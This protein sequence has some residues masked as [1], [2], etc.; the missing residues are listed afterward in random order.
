MKQFIWHHKKVVLTSTLFIFMPCLFFSFQKIYGEKEKVC[1]SITHKKLI[2]IS[3]YYLK[4]KKLKTRYFSLLTNSLQPSLEVVAFLNY[5]VNLFT[6]ISRID[7]K[8]LPFC[9]RPL[10]PHYFLSCLLV[11]PTSCI[12]WYCV[13]VSCGLLGSWVLRF[14]CV[15]G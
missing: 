3:V 4:R 10:L 9:E 6:I 5:W 2:F 12:Q 7:L 13:Y 8:V 1:R 15:H 11:P 14:F